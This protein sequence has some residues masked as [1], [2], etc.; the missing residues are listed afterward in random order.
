MNTTAKFNVDLNRERARLEKP[1]IKYAA[2]AGLLP[3]VVEEGHIRLRLP[4]GDMH[5]N[6]VG[7]AYAGSMFVAAEIACGSL[8]FCT[9]GS[10]R[11]VP[12]QQSA[13]IDF[14]KPLKGD[15]TVEGRLTR[16]EALELITP[17]LERGK[18]SLN[19]I[20]ELKDN[21]DEPVG[22]GAFKVYALPV[23]QK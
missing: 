20:M 19:L 11:W 23:P 15:L 4:L 9:Y 7:S 17:I 18:G 13:T 5:V 21:E 16:E 22:R 10:D 8:F 12:V 1:S 3:E 2:L 6:H 14:L